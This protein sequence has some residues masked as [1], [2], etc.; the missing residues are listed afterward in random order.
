MQPDKDTIASLHFIRGQILLEYPDKKG[1]VRKCVSPE[2]VRNALLLQQFDSGWLAPNTIR[3]GEGTDGPWAIQRYPATV[4]T[5]MF[6]GP[7]GTGPSGPVYEVKAP[8]P[9]LIFIGE[10]RKY[11][12]FAVR[13]WNDDATVLYHAPLPNVS[14]DGLIC[15]GTASPPPASPIA[16]SEAWQLFWRAAFNSD[17]ISGK[18]HSHPDSIITQLLTLAAQQST[19]Y[20]GKDLIR[21][22]LTMADVITRLNRED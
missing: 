21:T 5:L 6:D 20:P 3:H 13:V 2:S 14:A 18:S 22:R 12:V 11:S 4:Y 10:A 9:E 17:H 16:I 8:L 19:D 7:V 1:I 15:Y